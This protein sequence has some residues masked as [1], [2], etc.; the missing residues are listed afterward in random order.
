MIHAGFPARTS[1]C[2]PSA[3]LTKVPFE[4]REKSEL[5]LRKDDVM[6]EN[7]LVDVLGCAEVGDRLQQARSPW[8]R[9]LSLQG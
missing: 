7:G 2:S 8:V 1:A 6:C 4:G 9:K 3:R 5:P